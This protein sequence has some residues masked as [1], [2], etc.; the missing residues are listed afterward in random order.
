[1]PHPCT[2]AAP[3]AGLPSAGGL[4]AT[5]VEGDT[6]PCSAIQT[7]PEVSDRDFRVITARTDHKLMTGRWTADALVIFGI[8]GDLA[9]RMTIPALYELELR[10][11]LDCPIVG[12]A[13]RALAA[14]A[15]H[16]HIRAAVTAR[17]KI[18]EAVLARLL[19]RTTYV[20][21]DMTSGDVYDELSLRT[22]RV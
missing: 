8:T 17:H 21:G 19:Q 3:V 7:P 15:W 22:H 18:D 1:M 11:A 2:L 16:E 12:I 4:Q 20:A 14:D 13:S 9:R 5:L 10:G 6:G